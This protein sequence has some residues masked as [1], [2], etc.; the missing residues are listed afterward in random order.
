MCGGVGKGQVLS[1]YAQ[2]RIKTQ[3]CHLHNYIEMG[4]GGELGHVK[5]GLPAE[6]DHY[7]SL[8]C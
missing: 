4:E 6:R 2:N 3:H 7:A 1:S 5:T 8:A